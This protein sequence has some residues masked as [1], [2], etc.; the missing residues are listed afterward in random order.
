[1]INPNDPLA[2]FVIALLDDDEGINAAAYEKLIDMLDK[3]GEDD[4]LAFV[5]DNVDCGQKYEDT[6]YFLPFKVV[7]NLRVA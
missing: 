5:E 7:K 1:M 6:R 2:A 3:K 4:I